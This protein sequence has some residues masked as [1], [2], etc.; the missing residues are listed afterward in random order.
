MTHARSIELHKNKDQA[1]AHVPRQQQKV[2]VRQVASG[3]DTSRRAAQRP[4]P[5]NT[6]MGMGDKD[7][8]ATLVAGAIAGAVALTLF[9]KARGAVQT[10]ASGSASGQVSNLD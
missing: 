6:E 8:A 2:A 3:H 1:R 5:A 4:P 7:R 10:S 9:N